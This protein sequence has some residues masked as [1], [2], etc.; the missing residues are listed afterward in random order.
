MV[1]QEPMT[2]L[3]PVHRVGDQIAEVIRLHRGLGRRDAAR[4]ATRLS[5]RSASPIQAGAPESSR[6]GS[7]AA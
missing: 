1:F 2:S 5:A 6:T 4:E 3:N 7:P